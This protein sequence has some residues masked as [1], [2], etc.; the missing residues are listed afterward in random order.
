MTASRGLF[1][2]EWAIDRALHGGLGVVEKCQ[3]VSCG[4]IRLPGTPRARGQSFSAFSEITRST[5]RRP[6]HLAG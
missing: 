6:G 3:A 4:S 1:A 5:Q 2:S